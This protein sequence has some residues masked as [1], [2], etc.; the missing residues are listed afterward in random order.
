MEDTKPY[1]IARPTYPG[2]SLLY[3][4][5][6]IHTQLGPDN[7]H[8]LVIS[9]VKSATTRKYFGLIPSLT[10]ITYDIQQMENQLSD[11]NSLLC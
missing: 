1:K 6:V 2:F 11:Q 3:I 5:H 7:I 9:I 4:T 8:L 10:V